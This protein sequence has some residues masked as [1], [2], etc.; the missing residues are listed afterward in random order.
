[1]PLSSLEEALADLRAGKFLIVVD[2]ERRENEGDLVVLLGASK[3]DGDATALAGSEYLESVHGLVAGQP[4]LDLALETGVQRVCLRLVEE[5]MLHSAHD[6]AEGGL[7]V[8]IAESAVQGGLGFKATAKLEG[9]W[10]AALFGE[11]A[12]RIIISLD[13]GNLRQ[14][15]E[16]CREEGV[17][18]TSLGTVGG[19]GFTFSDL[20]D[21]PLEDLENAWRNGLERALER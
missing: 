21:L 15:E 1:M 5:G 16:V 14:V 8:A 3:I 12:S 17:P 2:D 6:C 13:S 11:T 7:A 4:S 9:R 20:L 18:Y 10:D 19:K